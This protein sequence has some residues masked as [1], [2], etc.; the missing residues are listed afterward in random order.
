VRKPL[1][2]LPALA[3]AVAAEEPSG[4][5]RQ[6]L[7]NLLQQ[8]CGSCHGLRFKGGLGPALLPENLRSKPDAVLIDTIMNGRAGTA[9]PPWREFLSFGEAEWLVDR[10]RNPANQQ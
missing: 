7:S 1:S 4:Q 5:R 8:D 10:L 2:L 6:E 9:M 3:F